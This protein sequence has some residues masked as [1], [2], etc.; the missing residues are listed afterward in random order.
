MRAR[1]FD[2][3]AKHNVHSISLR[4]ATPTFPNRIR[5][6]SRCLI[7]VV[8]VV[9]NLIAAVTLFSSGLPLFGLWAI[10]ATFLI[11]RAVFALCLIRE[12]HGMMYANQPRLLTHLYRKTFL[13]YHPEN[14][15]LSG[16]GAAAAYLRESFQFIL[17]LVPLIALVV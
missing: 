13:R 1:S 4:G 10:P 8:S 15:M 17:W 16:D 9:G 7:L 6:T 3:G 2:A 11:P 14:F 5:A 12:R